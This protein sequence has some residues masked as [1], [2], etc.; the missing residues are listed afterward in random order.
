MLIRAF[1][2]LI[3]ALFNVRGRFSARNQRGN[4]RPNIGATLKRARIQRV[5]RSENIEEGA[6][7]QG[8][9]ACEVLFFPPRKTSGAFWLVILNQTQ[10][11]AIFALKFWKIS[12]LA[13]AAA[14]RTPKKHSDN[15]FMHASQVAQVS[16][17][18]AVLFEPKSAENF[19][20]FRLNSRKCR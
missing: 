18:S 8:S 12:A 3:R 15:H 4:R 13:A 9:L 7:S 10:N 14:R 11:R 17:S 19:H 1:S 2:R 20:D 5:N 16:L 6:N